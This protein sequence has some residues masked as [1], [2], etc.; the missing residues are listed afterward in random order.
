MLAGYIP[1][2]VGFSPSTSDPLVC[3]SS[4]SFSQFNVALPLFA[5]DSSAAQNSL[6]VELL[7]NKLSCG[8]FYTTSISGVPTKKI[9]MTVKSVEHPIRLVSTPGAFSGSRFVT[10]KIVSNFYSDARRLGVPAVVVDSV[11]SNLSAKVDF[12]HSL[13]RGDTFEIMY[14]PKNVMLYS[15]ISSKRLKT[16]VYRVTQGVGSAYCFENGATVVAGTSSCSFAP[17]LK[18]KLCVS[19]PFG[20]RRH[21]VRGV[22]RWHTGVDLQAPHGTPVYAACD[23]V[24]TRASRYFG[25]GICVDIQHLS[26]YSS[27]YAHLSANTVHVGQR[28]KKGHMLGRVGMSGMSTGAHLHFEVAKNNKVVNPLSVKMIPIEVAYA[29]HV[30]GFNSLKKQIEKIS[31]KFTSR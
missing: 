27:R 8:A 3:E 19:S 31:N 14:S 16:A 2:F 29:S 6:V 10:G 22:W 23:G 12:K 20:S 28:I 1:V 30:D 25:Y 17:P 18:G 4:G 21:P 9:N 26:G 24:V 15:K 7:Q 5:E 13:K 11:I